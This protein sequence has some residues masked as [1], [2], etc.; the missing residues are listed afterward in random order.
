M[1][2]EYLEVADRLCGRI[3][4]DALWSGGLCN[5]TA[6]RMTTPPSYGALPPQLY[7]G[8]GGIALALWRMAQATGDSIFRRT[9]RGAIARSLSLLPVRANGFYVGGMGIRWASAEILGEVDEAAILREGAPDRTALDIIAG[10][11]GAL[12]ALLDFH[13]RTGKAAFLEL[14]IR[15]GDLLLTEAFPADDGLLWNTILGTEAPT[16]FAH[17]AAGIGWALL[18]L[19][20]ATGEARFRQAAEGAFRFE[21]ACFHP[22]EENWPDFR[23]EAPVYQSVW[24]HG[25]GGIALSRLRAWQILGDGVLLEEARAGLKILRGGFR[26]LTNFSLCHGTA[27]N[28]D[29]MLYASQV[30]REPEWSVAAEAAA[31]EG[32]ERFHRPR[33]FW[34][35]GLLRA[36]ETPDLLWGTAGIAYFYLRLAGAAAPTLLLPCAR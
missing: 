21:R 2:H 26:R 31:Q 24:C 17:G 20:L 29:L 11:A 18:E 12:V 23:G 9:A 25:A 36:V 6:D 3:C 35:S 27:G 15:H 1:N 34:P 22:V 30:L 28:A 8:S 5:W 10:S 14:A 7:S 13:R 32:I 19:W 33:A 16:G 4:R